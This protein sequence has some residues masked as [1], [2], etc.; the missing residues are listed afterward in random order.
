MK[1]DEREME[2]DSLYNESRQSVKEQSGE[3]EDEGE[4]GVGGRRRKKR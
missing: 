2:S 1:G 4:F 3:I